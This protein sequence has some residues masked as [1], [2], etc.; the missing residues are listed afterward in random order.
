MNRAVMARPDCH[1][2]LPLDFSSSLIWAGLG[3]RWLGHHRRRR[4]ASLSCFLALQTDAADF[5][6]ILASL[7]SWTPACRSLRAVLFRRRSDGSRCRHQELR[8]GGGG[9]TAPGCQAA[10]RP[11]GLRRR[12]RVAVGESPTPLI[13]TPASLKPWLDGTKPS[14]PKRK[15]SNLNNPRPNR[16]H[17]LRSNQRLHCRLLCD[18][19]FHGSHPTHRLWCY[20]NSTF[21][22]ERRNRVAHDRVAGGN[23]HSCWRCHTAGVVAQPRCRSAWR[24]YRALSPWK[25]SMGRWKRSAGSGVRL[26]K[27]VA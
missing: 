27:A 12:R 7:C 13:I 18:R 21:H 10:G 19:Y 16:Y 5:S 14:T 15:P 24:F 20:G 8:C 23:G 26:T 2:P 9:G 17:G 22:K 11:E 4:I 6:S 3:L 25:S 1:H